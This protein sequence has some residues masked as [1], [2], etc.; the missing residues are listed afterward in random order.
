MDDVVVPLFRHGV[1]CF[2]WN[3]STSIRTRGEPLQVPHM[4][5]CLPLQTTCVAEGHL[6]QVSS[7]ACLGRRC[8]AEQYASN[9]AARENAAAAQPGQSCFEL[10]PRRLQVQE[11]RRGQNTFGSMSARSSV[12]AQAFACTI[13]ATHGSLCKS[14]S[15]AVPKCPQTRGSTTWRRRTAAIH[16]LVEW[17][18]DTSHE[19]Q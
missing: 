18:P 3:C 17:L 5:E 14:P 4:R 2:P 12:V 19:S 9:V 8:G 6:V 13:T 15:C 11:L 1:P 10:Q 16:L 7:R